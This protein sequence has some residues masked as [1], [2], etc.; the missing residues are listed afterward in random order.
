MSETA[1]GWDLYR[2]FLAVMDA[3]SLSGAARDLGLAQPTVGRHIEALEAALGGQPLFTRSPGGLRPTE[4]AVALRPHAEAMAAAAEALIRTA[5]GEAEAVRGVIRVTA[6]EIVGVEVLPPIL[7]GFHEAYP[8]V[9]IELALSN[10]QEDLLRRE[11]DIAVRMARP[12]QGA[13]TA[14]RI[15]S[16]PLGLYAHSRYLAARGVPTR[17][18]DPNHSAIGFDRDLQMQRSLEER[19]LPLTREFFAFRSDGDLA[20]LAALRA[21]F[22]IGACQTGIARRDPDLMPVLEDVFR[23]DMEVWVAMHEDLKASRRMRLMFDWLAD[24]LAEYVKA[25]R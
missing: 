21:G 14:R 4:T 20:Q 15:G 5:S 18:D 11:S 7:T 13:L 1:P 3:G 24:G 10:R 19:Q 25:S 6:S 23:Y 12:A 8:E 17:I 9:S 22:G 16:V 2:T